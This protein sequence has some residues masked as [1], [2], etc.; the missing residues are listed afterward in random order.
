M[1]II[2]KINNNLKL[3]NIFKL[4][5]QTNLKSLNFGSTIK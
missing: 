3:K 4:Q 2:K 5:R 1:K